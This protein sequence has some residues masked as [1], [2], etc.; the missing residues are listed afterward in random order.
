M[1]CNDFQRRVT[2]FNGLDKNSNA[3]KSYVT[4]RSR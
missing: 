4:G 2:V 1:V 3:L